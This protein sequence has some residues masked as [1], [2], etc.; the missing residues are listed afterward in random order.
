MFHLSGF[1]LPKENGLFKGGEGVGCRYSGKLWGWK[2]KA[3]RCVGLCG[4]YINPGEIF[5][6][7]R[8]KSV[9]GLLLGG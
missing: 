8:E 7:E 3:L 5:F 4:N 1:D 2:L 6:W 9:P